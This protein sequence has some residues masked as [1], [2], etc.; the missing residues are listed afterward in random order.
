[1]NKPVTEEN[2]NEN[3]PVADSNTPT[4]TGIPPVIEGVYDFASGKENET[5]TRGAFIEIFGEDLTYDATTLDEGVFL[6]V[7]SRDAIKLPQV[8]WNYPRS[9]VFAMPY[10]IED[11]YAQVEIRSRGTLVNGPLLGDRLQINLTV[12]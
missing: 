4:F 5:L 7:P 12:I 11:A 3:T 6:L 10:L 1:M 2:P 8:I 9:T